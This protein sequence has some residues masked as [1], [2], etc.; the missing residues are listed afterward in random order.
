MTDVPATGQ[1]VRDPDPDEVTRGYAA[2]AERFVAWAR[3]EDAIRAAII[4]GSR[5][6]DDHAADVWADLDII[7]VANDPGRYVRDPAW[8]E[9]IGEPWIAFVEETPD[10][11]ALERR[12]LFAD[13]LDVDF[14]FVDAARVLDGSRV[15][16]ARAVLSRGMRVL[17][18]RDGLI[19]RIGIPS[20]PALP[21]PP[22][23]ETVRQVVSDFW[24][25]AVWT[26]KHLRRG[27]L[28]WAKSGC[29]GHLKELLRIALEWSAAVHGRD[30]WFRG[31][32]FEE[33][34]DPAILSRLDAAFARYNEADIWRALL[35][36]MDLFTEVAPAS[37]R[38]LGLPYPADAEVRAR[39]LVEAYVRSPGG[40]MPFAQRT[41]DTGPGR[42]GW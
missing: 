37:A 20:V 36:T 35:V 21:E 23:A 32:F 14:A 1:P 33:W 31:R 19:D 28:W 4:I 10:G 9:Q 11:T 30:H 41:N 16:M 42:T 2:I 27:E 15:A 25:H 24:Y 5:A 18:D 39:Q 38:A 34:V 6:R 40:D 17:L 26:A 29:D 12:I 7:V 3:T 8:A 22:D 13:G